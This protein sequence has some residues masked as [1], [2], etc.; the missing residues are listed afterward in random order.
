M[1]KVS[2]AKAILKTG[3]IIV[4]ILAALTIVIA[5]PM[6]IMVLL[7]A[8]MFFMVGYTLYTLT[9]DFYK[10]IECRKTK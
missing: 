4:A 3:V 8:I 6:V 7:F 2:L 10:D 5:Y 9:I 1:N